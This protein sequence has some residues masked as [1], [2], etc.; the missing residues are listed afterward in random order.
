MFKLK[1]LF[2]PAFLAHVVSWLAFV[3]A[4]FLAHENGDNKGKSRKQHVQGMMDETDSLTI[5]EH[6]ES[7]CPFIEAKFTSLDPV[8]SVY[9]F[10]DTRYLGTFSIELVAGLCMF[11]SHVS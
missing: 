7:D 9:F 8:K 10:W 3:V 6:F 4:I 11:A 5:K 2:H 1:G